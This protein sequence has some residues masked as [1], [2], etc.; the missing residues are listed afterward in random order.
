MLL[1]KVLKTTKYVVENSRKVKIDEEK[2]EKLGNFL[3]NKKIP[4]WSKIYHF[5]GTEKETV[6][7]L[8]ILDSINF[9]F[10]PFPGYFAFALALK[11]AIKNYP[12]LKAE[13]LS[14]IS[15]G[16][17]KEIFKKIGGIPL[18]KERKEILNGTGKV[19]LRKFDGESIN[20]LK[21]AQG[22]AQNLVE[23]LIENFPSFRDTAVFQNKKIYFLKRAQIFAADVYG[24]FDGKGIGLFS[25]LQELTCFP[26]YKIPQILNEFGVLKYS[27][28]LLN[29][30]KTK[31]EIKPF[32]REEI[33]IRANT[34][35]A[36]EKLKK[37]LEKQGRKIRSFEIDWILWNVAQGIKMK[38]SH[39]QTRTI[40]Y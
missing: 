26:D 15:L 21:E 4:S 29:K 34:V 39:H 9:S 5:Q 6:Q 10:F 1:E 7:Y 11:K 27:P 13:F 36:V 38:I 30:I 3:K 14:S 37:S 31:K 2:A 25:D 33:E 22:K 28:E 35:W 18:L 12:I 19:L 24:A 17:L 23:I 20:I 8:F 32:S 16:V 40:Y